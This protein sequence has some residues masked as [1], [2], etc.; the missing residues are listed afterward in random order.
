MAVVVH[1]GDMHSGHFVT[2]RR[3]PGPRAG[4]G[5]WL[6]VSDDSVRRASLQE[7]L[8]ASAYL[9]FYERVRGAMLDTVACSIDYTF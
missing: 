9:L 5:Q 1:H 2:Y 7:V 6:W 3:V 8:A 4:P